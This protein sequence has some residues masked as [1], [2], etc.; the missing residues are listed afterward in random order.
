MSG[1]PRWQDRAYQPRVRGLAV[2]AH[3]SAA[4]REVCWHRWPNGVVPLNSLNGVAAR[5]HNFRMG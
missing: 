1:G 2:G 5:C 3:G 4:H